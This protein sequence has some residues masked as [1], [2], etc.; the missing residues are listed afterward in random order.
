MKIKNC[1]FV[2]AVDS[3]DNVDHDCTA[4]DEKRRNVS[5]SRHSTW[6][7]NWFANAELS[8]KSSIETENEHHEMTPSGPGN[9]SWNLNDLKVHNERRNWLLT[10]YQVHE[11]EIEL[12]A[13]RSYRIRVKQNQTQNRTH[14][15]GRKMALRRKTST[16]GVHQMRPLHCHRLWFHSISFTLKNCHIL[17]FENNTGR[18]D[19]PTN[20]R[21]D[22]RTR[23]LIEMR[24][25][26]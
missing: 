17:S 18:T 8:D 11:G 22:R 2:L 5:Y 19:G 20:G 25:R 6:R 3:V 15:I 13:E 12:S 23:P 7:L 10:L 26:I 14:K 9:L 1:L 16:A 4:R 21:T 24:N